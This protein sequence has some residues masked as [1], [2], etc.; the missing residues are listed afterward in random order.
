MKNKIIKLFYRGFYNSTINSLEFDKN[1]NYLFCYSE[2]TI[3]IFSIN[4]KIL[5]YYILIY[6]IM[7]KFISN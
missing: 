6:G 7:K 2:Y 5:H 1:D 3:H 4:K